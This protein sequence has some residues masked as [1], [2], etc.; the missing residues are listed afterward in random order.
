M[1]YIFYNFFKKRLIIVNLVTVYL[2]SIVFL[3]AGS[4]HAEFI[5]YL[6]SV[7]LM[8]FFS[9]HKNS[10]AASHYM[11][12]FIYSGFVIHPSL[13]LFDEINYYQKGYINYFSIAAL[14]LGIISYLF[15]QFLPNKIYENKEKLFISNQAKVLLAL[16]VIV[17]VTISIINF[18]EL[19][20][21]RGVETST[22]HNIKL[23]NFFNFILNMIIPILTI[24]FIHTYSKNIGNLEIVFLLLITLVCTVS[25]GSRGAFLIYFIV[26]YEAFKRKIKLNDLT[27]ITLIL[28]LIIGLYI[29]EQKR[30]SIFAKYS[31]QK[32]IPMNNSL[33]LHTPKIQNFDFKWMIYSLLVVRWIGADGLFTTQ[34]HLSKLNKVEKENLK[35]RIINE[36]KD[37]YGVNW[38]DPILLKRSI[39]TI[40]AH[41]SKKNLNIINLPGIIGFLSVFF[42]YIG[43]FIT[44]S[45]I[46]CVL[47]LLEFLSMRAFIGNWLFS[48]IIILILV[49]RLVNFGIYFY[50]TYKIIIAVSLVYFIYGFLYYLFSNINRIKR[51]LNNIFR[52]N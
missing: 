25:F 22:F 8:N 2:L 3:K 17:I 24:F 13:I 33:M 29:V 14:S 26:V 47:H 21:F 34:E 16:F 40:K 9:L 15:S 35:I 39:E 27:I 50:D 44:F 41:N 10:Y 31:L 52:V 38:Y 6:F 49:N 46:L 18:S 42:D 4:G 51:K 36:K 48:T 19:I 1:T 12:L 23:I 37:K 43:V 5:L 7:F 28:S 45:L 11:W 30:H 32:H 20:Y